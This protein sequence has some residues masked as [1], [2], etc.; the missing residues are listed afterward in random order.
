MTRFR[1]LSLGL[2]AVAIATTANA[3]ASQAV[4]IQLD[5][6]QS[7]GISLVGVPAS[8]SAGVDVSAG[9]P[10]ALGSLTINPSWDLKHNR[11]VTIDAYFT[12]DL[13]GDAADGSPTI[14][15]SAFSGTKRVGA[16]ASAAVSW[17][18]PGVGNAVVLLGGQTGNGLLDLPRQLDASST[19][20]DVS[21]SLSV[22]VPADAYP[23]SY[24][25]SLTFRAVVN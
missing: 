25:T 3:Q 11:N 19:S 4:V 18:G 5:K 14:P 12:Q 9:G 7:V 23:S 1:T 6:V 8:W 10:I 17:I 24:T 15:V 22:S 21:F 16:G 13:T 20:H 2:A